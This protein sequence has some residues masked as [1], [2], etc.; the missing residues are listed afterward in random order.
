M[1]KHIFIV[2]KISGKGKAYKSIPLI[3]KV[4]KEL[5]IEYVI[6]VSNYKGHIKEIVK[7]YSNQKDIILYSVG[8]DGTFLEIISDINPSIPL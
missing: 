1:M 2:N 4:C 3:E 8:G 6:E 7:S 5:N